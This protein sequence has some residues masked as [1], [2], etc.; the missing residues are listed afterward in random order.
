MSSIS[1]IHIIGAGMAGL[2]A[3][4]A[5]SA[6]GR[7]VVYET[8]PQA[9]GRCRSFYDKKLRTTIDNGNHLILGA[10]TATLDYLRR[11]GT[12]DHFL[13][14][15]QPVYPFIDLATRRHWHHKPP[16]FTGIAPWQWR[17]LL[18]LLWAAEHQTVADCIPPNSP[19]YQRLVEPL[20]LAALNTAPQ[21]AS[22][23][24]LR[25]VVQRLALGGKSAWRSYLPIDGL[26]PA[27]VDPALLRIK[28]RGGSIH[29][30][31]TIQR[32]SFDH[33]R[34][35]ALHTAK[36]AIALSASDRV[37][38]AVPPAT[39]ES[40]LP[41]IAPSLEYR[42]ILNGHFLWPQAGALREAMP[43]LGV[44]GGLAQWIFFHNGRLSTTTSAADAVTEQD[45][46][47]LAQ[48][49][50]ADICRALYMDGT[51]MPPH[52]I[53]K[54]KRAGFAA[55]PHNIAKR[56]E[57]QTAYSNLFLAGDYLRSPLPATIEAAIC[58]GVEAAAL[59][60][61]QNTP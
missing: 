16:R 35:T 2:A 29:L 13:V 27:L 44:L 58:S 60:T 5:A 11:I 8:A 39:L 22:A 47:T 19:L 32:L 50:W 42:A 33:Q 45:E 1:T 59:A 48:R 38:L 41:E 10:N 15:A 17:H 28:G 21:E 46:A 36:D 6:Y 14:S 26:S 43:F 49:L 23:R 12:L 34:V 61:R 18:R 40:L 25:Q 55:T 9:G 3:A 53:I 7:V 37:I 56:P 20:T 52:R 57:A 31:T 30:H 51:A 54:E 4:E 24:M